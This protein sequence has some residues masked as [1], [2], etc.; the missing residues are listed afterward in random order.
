M[1]EATELSDVQ[2]CVL[3]LLMRAREKGVNR[4][5]RMELLKSSTLPD[6]VKMQLTFA[7]L[8]MPK[9]LVEWFGEHDFRITDEGVQV[10]NLRFDNS[11]PTAIADDVILLPD[12]SEGK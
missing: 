4:L 8:V 2:W 12:W 7:A 10:Y 5:N 9:R 1:A 6:K 3:D 11:A